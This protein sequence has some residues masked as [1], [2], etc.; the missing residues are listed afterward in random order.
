MGSGVGGLSTAPHLWA[1]KAR[2][3]GARGLDITPTKTPCDLVAQLRVFADCDVL[4][5]RYGQTVVSYP[6]TRKTSHLPLRSM[7]G[8]QAHSP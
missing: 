7:L 8:R 5:E 6:L 4:H 1:H 3:P 2:A